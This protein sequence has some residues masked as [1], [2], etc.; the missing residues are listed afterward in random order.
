LTEIAQRGFKPPV[1]IHVASPFELQGGI[2]E[3]L[4]R[5]ANGLVPAHAA[6]L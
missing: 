6:A 5:R 1:D 3:L 2:A 4:P